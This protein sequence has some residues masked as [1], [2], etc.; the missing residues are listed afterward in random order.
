M[1]IQDI[2][3]LLTDLEANSQFG[4]ISRFAIYGQTG[5]PASNDQESTSDEPSS[6]L[7]GSSPLPTH[8]PSPSS[9]QGQGQGLFL[10]NLAVLTAATRL[11]SDPWRETTVY[12]HFIALN[13]WHPSFGLE[14]RQFLQLVHIELCDGTLH[15]A[16]TDNFNPFDIQE[17]HQSFPE[18]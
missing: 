1:C 2:H 7:P 10:I 11:R 8:F 17:G 15:H 16:D 18:G 6:R 9:S 13:H 5:E 4:D 3:T 14:F 12:I